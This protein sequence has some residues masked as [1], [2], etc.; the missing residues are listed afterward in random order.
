MQTLKRSLIR[1]VDKV[2]LPNQLLQSDSGIPT[3]LPY[4]HIQLCVCVEI[5]LCQLLET[6]E[7]LRNRLLSFVERWT[8][9]LQSKE[10]HFSE[11]REN[12]TVLFFDGSTNGL[13]RIEIC[14]RDYQQNHSKQ[15]VLSSL[16]E[17]D[18]IVILYGLQHNLL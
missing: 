18:L 4:T 14:L 7:S 2:I 11:T 9:T 10:L 13:K 3:L 15:V 5:C 8:E 12:P 6:E 17:E 16:T 1:Y